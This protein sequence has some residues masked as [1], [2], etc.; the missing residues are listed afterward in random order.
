MKYKKEKVTALINKPNSVVPTARVMKMLSEIQREEDNSNFLS[1]LFAKKEKYLPVGCAS[2][3][4]NNSNLHELFTI[5]KHTLSEGGGLSIYVTE[6]IDVDYLIQRL[7][8]LESF[9]VVINGKTRGALKVY[10]DLELCSLQF[11]KSYSWIKKGLFV[12]ESLLTNPLLRDVIDALNFQRISISKKVFTVNGEKLNINVRGDTALPHKGTCLIANVDFSQLYNRNR[13]T[14]AFVSCMNWIIS[15]LDSFDTDTKLYL[16]K[17][18]DGQVGLSVL[19]LEQFLTFTNVPYEDLANA[20][21]IVT[22][23]Q[24]PVYWKSNVKGESI[25]LAIEIQKAY[26]EAK[27]IAQRNK[28]SRAFTIAPGAN[29]SLRNQ[30]KGI[31]LHDIQDPK[32][33]LLL[34]CAW[35]K[36]IL[37][38]G[39][40]HPMPFIWGSC[41]ERFLR[42]WFLSPLSNLEINNHLNTYLK[43]DLQLIE[44]GCCG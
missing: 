12:D 3:I 8:E 4:A 17:K 16:S 10:I 15:M 2:F 5:A 14:T 42:T 19:G 21:A 34:H 18:E 44:S 13:I 32:S 36:L 25:R 31:S 28:L 37:D 40:G 39:L 26:K 38:T 22:N 6:V 29:I 9:R 41:H 1:S 20:L 33:Y 43:K 27:I 30:S 24:H 23:L 35:Q 7:E 11:L